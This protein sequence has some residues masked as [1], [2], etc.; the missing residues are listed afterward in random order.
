MKSFTKSIRFSLVS[1]AIG[2]AMGCL[3]AL[4]QFEPPPGPNDL[5]DAAGVFLQK[6]TNFTVAIG[7]ITESDEA[8]GIPLDLSVPGT[9]IN[10]FQ[11]GGPTATISDQWQ[12]QP[13]RIHLLSDL[14]GQTGGL[15]PRTGA[16]K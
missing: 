11:P 16:I 12:I 7:G 15:A 8:A 1:V 6:S 4:A 13:Y 14:P 5:S 3:N 9:V 2:L 10:A